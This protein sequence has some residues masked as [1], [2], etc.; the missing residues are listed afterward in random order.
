[1]P[2]FDFTCRHCGATE[3]RIVPTR[4]EP[5]ATCEACGGVMDKQPAA[6][7]FTVRGFNAKNGYAGAK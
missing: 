7:N 4:H 2:R 5:T 1:M 6:P 3:E